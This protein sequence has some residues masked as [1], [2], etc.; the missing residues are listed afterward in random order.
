MDW[1]SPLA[2]FI[3]YRFGFLVYLALQSSMVGV[4]VTRSLLPLQFLVGLSK[5]KLDADVISLLKGNL[6]AVANE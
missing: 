1:L 5:V 2:D 6:F 4:E 3:W